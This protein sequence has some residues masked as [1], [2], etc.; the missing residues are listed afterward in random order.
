MNEL[1]EQYESDE[2][3]ENQL[4][5]QATALVAFTRSAGAASWQFRRAVL[6]RLPV[7][8]Y[9]PRTG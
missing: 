2:D 6:Q 5:E 8:G 9:R 1:E 3:D 7:S 4:Q